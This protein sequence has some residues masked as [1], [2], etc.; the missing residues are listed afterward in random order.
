MPRRAAL[1]RPCALCGGTA[2]LRGAGGWSCT[3]CGWSVGAYVDP[4]LPLPRIDVVYYLRLGE[5]VKIGTTFTPRHRFAVL[6]HDEVLAF[7]RGD[8]RVERERHAEFAADRLGTSEWFAFSPG[9][10]THVASLAAGRDP[11]D[12]LARWLAEELAAR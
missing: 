9:I 11:W 4:D 2:G 6:P 8:R 5:R 3:T 10:R 12:V 1:E 7:E